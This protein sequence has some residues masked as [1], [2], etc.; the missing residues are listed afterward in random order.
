MIV[1]DFSNI[2][3]PIGNVLFFSGH[4]EEFFCAFGFQQFDCDMPLHDFL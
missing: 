2:Y 1:S 4:F 3:F